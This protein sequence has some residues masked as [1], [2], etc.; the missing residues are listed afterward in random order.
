MLRQLYRRS[1]A[2]AATGAGVAFHASS[3]ATCDAS[4]S[5]SAELS[6]LRAMEKDMTERWIKDEEGW[7][8]LPSR[9]WPVHQPNLDQLAVLQAKIQEECK[10]SGASCNALRFDLATLNVFNNL[11]AERGF[12]MYL[13]L[14]R[15]GDVNGLVAVGMCLVEGYGVEQDYAAGIHFLR[16]ASA[17]GHAQA[18]YE[19][20]VLYYTGAA[21]EDLPEDESKAL[22][23]FERAMARGKFSYAAYMVADLLFQNGSK[24][25]YTRALQLMYTAAEAGHRYA[26]QEI[27]TLL[28][29]KHRILKQL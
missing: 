23:Y 13:A 28:S 29:G 26:R 17:A 16:Q 8:K 24:D 5:F 25:D 12:Q 1:V 3:I 9:V 11:D 4:Q 20:G 15:E 6:R 27:Q 14:A 19:L 10:T 2:I 22:E 7:R 18:D 21:G